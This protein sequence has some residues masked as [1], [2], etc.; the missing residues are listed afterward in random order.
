MIQQG[1]TSPITIARLHTA[2][3]RVTAERVRCQR[4]R[5]KAR[6]TY[7]QSLS[8]KAWADYARPILK[9]TTA[10]TVLASGP[11]LQNHYQTLLH[12]NMPEIPQYHPPPNAP[13]PDWHFT[14]PFA[15]IEVQI[16]VARLKNSATG[17]DRITAYQIRQIPIPDLTHHLNQ[18]IA[19]NEV[20]T[21]WK[22]SILV[23]IPKGPVDSSKDPANTRGIALQSAMRKLYT[24]LLYTRLQEYSEINDL[25][26]PLQN[27]FR[28]NHRTADNIFIL[29]TLHEKALQHRTPLLLAQIDIRKAFDSV[30]RAS[31]FEMLY[32]KGIHGPL[33]DTLRRAYTGQEVSLRANKRYSAMISTDIG[34]PQGDPLSP[35][36]FILYMSNIHVEHHTDP[37][38][39][40]NKLPYLALADDYTILATNPAALQHKL[41][42]FAQ[43]CAKINLYVNLAK[44]TL[45]TIGTWTAIRT[46]RHIH[47]NLIPVPRKQVITINGFT[48]RSEQLVNGWD[49]DST[50]KI[51]QRRAAYAFRNLYG[52]RQELGLSTPT[53]LLNQY[54]AHVESQLLYAIESR[55]DTSIDT[56][57]AL[58][59]AEKNYVRCI[60]GAQ[61][62]SPLTVLYRD[63]KMHPI[64]HQTLM[65][66][67]K[68]YN[69]A[70]NTPPERPIFWAIQEQRF[71]PHGW[72][73]N[74]RA[75]FA[76][77]NIDFLRT[78]DLPNFNQLVDNI[79][80]DYEH[81]TLQNEIQNWPRMRVWQYANETLRQSI[82]PKLAEYLTLPYHLARACVRL[83]TSTHNIA[84]HR[85][86]MQGR[87]RER[88]ARTCPTC[89]TFENEFHSLVLCPEFTHLREPLLRL[90]PA[91]QIP[92]HCLH[93]TNETYAIFLHKV[94][95]TIDKRYHN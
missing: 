1:D 45:F 72:L 19:A 69:Y 23:T 20:P 12:Q 48:L 58:H 9:G 26:P 76:E 88:E 22:R 83:R 42:A 36:L 56:T 38:L 43:Q 80:W 54:K 71:I 61:P 49:S 91:H 60:T 75:Q 79:F 62:R 44:C 84:V 92:F 57:T 77:Y 70:A 16:G 3:N 63:L 65:H 68:F 73:G 5:I 37:T 53:Q 41:S 13:Q 50:A 85:F 18:I 32:A 21:N 30:D 93:N 90:H 14:N 6:T 34:V 46:I 67:A 4:A 74:L 33:I 7:L 52:A 17:E 27:G 95:N 82:P 55:F 86:R 66:T 47:I 81:T 11:T 25:L 89:Q 8:D 64:Q 51:Q 28:Q 31:L 78:A 94:L 15:E 35:L 59:T 2:R 87:R 39:N 24:L 29:R 10:R 40:G